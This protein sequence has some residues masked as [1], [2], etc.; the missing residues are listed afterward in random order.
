MEI[1]LI[2]TA[3][4]YLII[5]QACVVRVFPYAPTLSFENAS[6]FVR[7]GLL[8]MNEKIP[9]LDFN[10]TQ[11]YANT[12]EGLYRLVLVS[13]LTDSSQYNRYVIL[14]HD[15]PKKM[16]VKEEHLHEL[17]STGVLHRYIAMQLSITGSALKP[18]YLLNLPL[19]ETE[20]RMQ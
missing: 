6:E 12:D 15:E 16:K 14:A 7:G 5:P 17:D 19:I 2:P 13:T 1:M 10:F 4:A 3:D 20:L 11:A 8:I 18:I 9:L